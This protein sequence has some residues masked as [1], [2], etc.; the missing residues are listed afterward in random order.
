VN[1]IEL[2]NNQLTPPHTFK[3]KVKYADIKIISTVL[4]A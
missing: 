4:S 1:G 3:F 2:G